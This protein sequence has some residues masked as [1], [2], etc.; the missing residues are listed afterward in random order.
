MNVLS[1][2]KNLDITYGEL[3]NAMAWLKFQKKI[4]RSSNTLKEEILGRPIMVIVYFNKKNDPFY[5]LVDHEANALVP[6]DEIV[7]LSDE[8]Y[9]FGYIKHFDDLAKM[10][11]RER[12]AKQG[13][14]AAS[15]NLKAQRLTE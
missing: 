13:K 14:P 6:K 5:R 15:K 11:E 3:E 10:I 7:M 4:V 12:L 8:L 1:V 9:Q 2:Y